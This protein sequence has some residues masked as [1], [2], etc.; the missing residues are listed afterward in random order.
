MKNSQNAANNDL[1]NKLL[2]FIWRYLKNKKWCLFGITF[3][4][5]VHSIEKM[6]RF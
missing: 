4:G 6:V 3:V 5:I 2:P 1:P